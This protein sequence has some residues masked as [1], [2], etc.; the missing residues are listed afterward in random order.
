MDKLLNSLRRL[1][2]D[3]V[4]IVRNQDG[5]TSALS[6]MTDWEDGLKERC[7]TRREREIANMVTVGRLIAAAAL[8]RDHSIGAHFRSDQPDTPA[9]ES[10]R[11][12]QLSTAPSKDE[13][14]AN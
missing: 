13:L 5:L 4:G 6:Q 12:V 10:G 2:W 11:H 3:K 9:G 14:I 1:M 8:R 7:G